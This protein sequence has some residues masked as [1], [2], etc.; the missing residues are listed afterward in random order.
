MSNVVE[1]RNVVKTYDLGDN[2]KVD[3]LRSI[4]L[5]IK[6]GEFVSIMGPSGCGKTTLLNI[7][8]GLD[9]PTDGQVIIDGIDITHMNEGEL[10]RI[11]REKIGFIFQSFNLV[12]LLTALENVQIPMVFAGRFSNSEI[13]ERAIELLRLVGL[14]NRLHHRPTQMSGGEQQRVAIARALAN[15]PSIILADEPTGNIDR[16]TGWKIMHLIKSLNETLGQTCI[17]VTHDPTIAQISERILYILDGQ[18]IPEPP[19]LTINPSSNI[20]ADERRQMLLAELKWLEVSIK[21][22]EAKKMKL[23]KESY[24]QVKLGYEKRL[25][26]LK[27]AI[28]EEYIERRSK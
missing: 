6:R 24:I 13:R 19:K 14:E 9:S 8:G 22:L 21:N 25:E 27:K 12:P 20:L 16:E 1:L 18:I 3:A 23:N 10:A 2:I 26:R 7:I 17:T 11:R 4:N 15:E 28:Q 5:T